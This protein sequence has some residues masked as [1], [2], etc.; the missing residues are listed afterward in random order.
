MID[1]I[2]DINV[3]LKVLGAGLILQWRY[4]LGL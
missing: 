2:V 1:N 3:E 4:L